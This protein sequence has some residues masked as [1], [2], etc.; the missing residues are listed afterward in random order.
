M[1]LTALGHWGTDLAVP[2][3]WIDDGVALVDDGGGVTGHHQESSDARRERWIQ[4]PWAPRAM[5]PVM[6][7]GGEG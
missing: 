7:L 2:G 4:W 1:D 3:P 6:E 5:D